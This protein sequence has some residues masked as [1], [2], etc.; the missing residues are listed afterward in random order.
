MRSCIVAT[1]LLFSLFHVKQFLYA[2]EENSKEVGFGAFIH[3]MFYMYMSFGIK[4]TH[5]MQ[6][7]EIR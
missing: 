2:R 4:C 6:Q 7:L 3:A 5:I 1:F